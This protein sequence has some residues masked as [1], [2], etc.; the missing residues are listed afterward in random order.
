LHPEKLD[1]TTRKKPHT[2]VAGCREMEKWK[3][4]KCMLK[5][6]VTEQ[7]FFDSKFSNIY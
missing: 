2:T 7:N 3:S 1:K 4:T 5:V 6:I